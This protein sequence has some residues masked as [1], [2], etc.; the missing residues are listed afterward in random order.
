MNKPELSF[1]APYRTR[2]EQ[3]LQNHLMDC[4]AP[5]KLREAIE[6]SLFNGGKRIR[7]IL[8][9]ATAEVLGSE[10]SGVDSAACAVELIHTYSLIHDDLPSMDDDSLRRGKPS[11]HVAFDE[12]TAILAGDALQAMA[13]ELLSTAS[14]P[15]HIVLQ[16]IQELARASGAEGMVAGQMI[17]L[18]SER[19][20]IDAATLETMHQHKTGA[21]IKASVGLA[22]LCCNHS[23]QQLDHLD[24]FA[25]NI[26]LA[27]QVRDDIL[28]VE[29]S[30]E[31]MG[32]R[33]GADSHLG[34]ST[35]VSLHG[36]QGARTK[37]REFYQASITSLQSFGSA[38]GQLRSLADFV[39]NRSL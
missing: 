10:S 20:Q 9:Y 28:D 4:D 13:F 16:M 17:D 18:E 7:P 22:A 23:E 2:V 15:A 38:A 14:Q 21:L 36:M 5:E 12:A 34:K 11:T 3:Q 31:V 1:L 30:E 37:L 29:G 8:A 39:V 6:Y 25:H 24:R 19:V 35:Y 26:G 27:F 32:K 33:Q